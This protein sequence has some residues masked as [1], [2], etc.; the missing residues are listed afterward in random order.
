[1]AIKYHLGC[2][3]IYLNGYRNVD[4]PQSEH[5]TITV[6]ADIYSDLLELKYEPCEEIRSHHVFEH[7][8]FPESIALLIKWTDALC[9]GGILRIDV[10]D[11]E[12]LFEEFLNSRQNMPRS[13]KLLRLIYGSHE[14]DWAYH[15]NGWTEKSLSYVLEKMG[16]GLE[17]AKK[18]GNR[19]CPFPNCGI[20]MIFTKMGDVPDKISIGEEILKLYT[21]PVETQLLSTFTQKLR[22]LCRK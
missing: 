1:M 13:L 19:A 5:T 21:E 8:N 15:V 3:S 16:M 20:D 2:G 4:F 9:P 11:I 10:P 6:K 22:E 17:D 18:Y 12:I 14:A 7:F